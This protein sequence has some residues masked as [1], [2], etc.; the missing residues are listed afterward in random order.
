MWTILEGRRLA[1]SPGLGR[2]GL[3]DCLCQVSGS[4]VRRQGS[5]K[6]EGDGPWTRPGSGDSAV[7]S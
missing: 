4:A 6:E 3:R 2:T 1:D 7:Y 5:G